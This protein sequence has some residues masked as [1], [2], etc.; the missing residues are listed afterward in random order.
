L[1]VG[2]GGTSE[3]SDID[4]QRNVPF[5]LRKGNIVAIDVN[6]GQVVHVGVGG[7]KGGEQSREREQSGGHF[8]VRGG[9]GVPLTKPVK[10]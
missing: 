4:N 2:Y 3:G 5:V 8:F 9:R 10:K 1:V 6:A 7:R